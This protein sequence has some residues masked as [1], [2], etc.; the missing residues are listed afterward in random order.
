MHH[1][2][3]ETKGKTQG[4]KKESNTNRGT[5]IQQELHNLLVSVNTGPV[6]WGD[7]KG[8]P[9]GHDPELVESTT[10][11]EELHEGFLF[12]GEQEFFHFFPVAGL[13]KRRRKK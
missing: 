5:M 9:G 4:N 6:Q 8:V 10:G 3:R 1:L 2:K 7:S 12:L 13:K 11:S